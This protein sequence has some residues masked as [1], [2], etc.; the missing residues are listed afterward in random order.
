LPVLHHLILRASVVKGL[1]ERGIGV[2]VRVRWGDSVRMQARSKVGGLRERTADTALRTHDTHPSRHHARTWK[3]SGQC[4][5]D[6]ALS[7][8][9]S[10]LNNNRRHLSSSRL[11]P[12]DDRVQTQIERGER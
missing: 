12:P 5:L 4:S 8:S 10:F 11:H 7:R 3:E 6:R 1:S 2:R 9:S